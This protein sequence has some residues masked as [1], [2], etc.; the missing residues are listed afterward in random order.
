MLVHIG[1]HKTGT[2]WL[3]KEFF[4]REEFELLVKGKEGRAAFKR[5]FFG[6]HPLDFEAFPLQKLGDLRVQ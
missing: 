2:T 6:V 4:V 3:Q 5:A 1:Y